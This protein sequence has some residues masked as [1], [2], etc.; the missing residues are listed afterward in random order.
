MISMISGIVYVL[1]TPLILGLMNVKVPVGG[2]ASMLMNAR[3]LAS[4]SHSKT[5]FHGFLSNSI[6]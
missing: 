3:P 5:A 6:A 2:G 1:G 4:A